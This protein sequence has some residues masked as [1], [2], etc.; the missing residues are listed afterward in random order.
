MARRIVI[1]GGTHAG[2]TAAARA[3]ELD[4]D[5]DIT[6]VQRGG[7]LSFSFTGLHHYVSGEV[8][9]LSALDQ[10]DARF[11]ER[12]YAVKTRLFTTATAIDPKQQT[13][14]LRKDGSADD[15]VVSYDALIFALGAKSLPVPGVAGRNVW[16]LRT[17]KDAEAIVAARKGGA[18]RAVVIGGGSFGLEATDGLSRAGFEVT[19]VEARPTLLH[20]LSPHIGSVLMAT[21]QSVATVFV[22][23]AVVA[24]DVEDDVV[25]AVHLADGR[26]V[27]CDVVVVCAGVAPRTEL[28]AAA[29]IA[30]SDDGAVVVDDRAAVVGVKNIYAAGASVA[31]KDAVAGKARW[32]AQA[33]I[34]DK[35]A[36]A[37]GE[38]AAGGDV[39][40]PHFAGT[41]ALRLG[42]VVV[43][44]VGLSAAEAADAFGEND[45]D[46]SL[47]PGRSHEGFFPGSRPLF[48]ELCSQRSTGKVLGACAV[49]AAADKRLDVVAT[50]I[51]GG[52]TVEQLAAVD[53][54]AAAAIAP[55]RDVV[56]STATLAAMERRGLGR[57][58]PPSELF[59]RSD[60]QIVDVRNGSTDDPGL[61]GAHRIPLS[62]LRARLSELD[63]TK[64][65]AV[66]CNRGRSG[67]LAGRILKQKGFVDVS[68]VAGG[69]SAI[70]REKPRS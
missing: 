21:A 47:V 19:L 10:E 26:R 37:A 58:I 32:W 69:L 7:A 54:S 15:D 11:F 3:R 51:V 42:D 8:P 2:P 16:S 53:L 29:G 33:A 63:P 61:E 70:R 60:W 14:T 57:S 45:V 36:Q 1:V 12:S 5:A 49:G 44:H 48:F 31:V 67:W 30:L 35:V 50:A 4:E 22:G 27:D 20:R 6:I 56:N 39:R 43:G 46:T 65:T 62:T 52:L 17:L 41:T 40:V 18:R 55:L 38:N 13:V 68:V 9:Q 24:A 64:P 23:N 66:H 59:A 25:R 28:L 34:A